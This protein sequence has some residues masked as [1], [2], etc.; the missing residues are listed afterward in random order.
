[1]AVWLVVALI[2]GIVAACIARAKGRSMIGWFFA[3]FGSGIIGIIFIALKERRKVV[4][5]PLRQSE[6]TFGTSEYNI[7]SQRYDNHPTRIAETVE[8]LASFDDQVEVERQFSQVSVTEEDFLETSSDVPDVAKYQTFQGPEKAESPPTK[9]V[10]RSTFHSPEPSGIVSDDFEPVLNREPLRITPEDFKPIS[11]QDK[12]SITIRPEDFKEVPASKT[13]LIKERERFLKPTSINVDESDFIA[14]PTAKSVAKE[15]VKATGMSLKAKILTFIIVAT[16][17]G[18]AFVAYEGGLTEA[19]NEVNY[20]WTKLSFSAASA[21]PE[22]VCKMYLLAQWKGDRG[23]AMSLLTQDTQRV[24]VDAE[25]QQD[26]WRREQVERLR[27][28]RLTDNEWQAL[29]DEVAKAEP[30]FAAMFEG[31]QFTYRFGETLFAEDNMATVNMQAC[32][33]MKGPLFDY[34]RQMLQA[35]PEPE[36]AKGKIS[37]SMERFFDEFGSHWWNFKFHVL[38]ENGVWKIDD[39]EIPIGEMMETIFSVFGHA[40]SGI[41]LQKPERQTEL[42]PTSTSTRSELF[43]RKPLSLP[44]VTEKELQLYREAFMK[45]LAE[46]GADKATRNSVKVTNV[47]IGSHGFTN[48]EIIR[49]LDRIVFYSWKGRAGRFN[50]NETPIGSVEFFYMRSENKWVPKNKR[51]TVAEKREQIVPDKEF[52]NWHKIY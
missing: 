7:S 29:E 51:A 10:S 45:K 46:A 5:E 26:S 37:R 15:V 21:S 19:K 34:W 42:I 31:S 18:G 25:Q 16:A 4:N 14:K 52:K 2:C 17:G 50:S 9:P 48:P 30:Q 40:E 13:E 28:Q 1:M 33:Q 44:E 38:R 47:Y 20:V 32:F 6:Q 27:G 22:E 12:P 23:T 8:P 36:A 41:E 49:T 43:V 35:L 3:G 39:I 24:M 11:Y